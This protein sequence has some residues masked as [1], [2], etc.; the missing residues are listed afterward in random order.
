M[1]D[2]HGE[3]ILNTG[4]HIDGAYIR[5][6]DHLN[7]RPAYKGRHIRRG[8]ILITS[9]RIVGGSIHGGLS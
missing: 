8:I 2:I 7:H 1:L 5:V 3:T 4:P 6:G 9:L